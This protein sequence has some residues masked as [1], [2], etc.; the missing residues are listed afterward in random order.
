MRDNNFTSGGRSPLHGR[1]SR[2]EGMIMH[3]TAAQP[4]FRQRACPTNHPAV[5]F[6][7]GATLGGHRVR[8]GTGACA[9]WNR[10]PRLA[11]EMH[12]A[13][14][15]RPT[16]HTHPTRSPAKPAD[17]WVPPDSHPSFLA[18]R[19]SYSEAD[20]GTGADAWAD[21]TFRRP[22]FYFL[23][24]AD[25]S[26]MQQNLIRPP[27]PPRVASELLFNDGLE[28]RADCTAASAASS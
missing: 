7:G 17:P 24:W 19:A 11:S 9:R 15:H 22:S 28:A 12:C 2:G 18:S 4:P 14:A 25:S 5:P 6:T 3:S 27:R 1:R 13:I 20:R 23:Q 16:S 10:H 26:S 21:V 8:R